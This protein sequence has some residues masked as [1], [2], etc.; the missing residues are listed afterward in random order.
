MRA[1][2]LRVGFICVAAALPALAEDF[3]QNVDDY[4]NLTLRV[5]PKAQFR[6]PMP[7]GRDLAFSYEMK[8]AKPL[9]DQ[10]ITADFKLDPR[11]EQFYRHFWDKIFVA[12]GSALNIGTESIPLSCVYI[13]G[14]DNRFAKKSNP[15]IPDF[16]L[17]VY[18]VANEFSC[19]GPINPGW[20]MNGGRKETW[21]T[22]VYFEVKDPT[23]M[24]PVEA[25]IRYRWNEF[26]AY[27]ADQGRGG[28]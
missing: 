18:L 25:K 20:P 26:P 2:L 13:S 17:R 3:P 4:R 11:G 19:T 6:V 8:L 7:D 12:D 24:L 14:Q 28:P 23:I 16:V 15:L 10:P 5:R 21:D 1:G 27:L 22:Y 9:F